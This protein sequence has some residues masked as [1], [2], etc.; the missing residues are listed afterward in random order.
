V[1]AGET[2]I[3]VKDGQRVLELQAYAGDEKLPVK[4]KPSI[5]QSPYHAQASRV[6]IL[7][8]HPNELLIIV[9]NLLGVR[10]YS[11]PN[12]TSKYKGTF[13]NGTVEITRK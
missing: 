3:Q 12:I 4:L 5:P 8:S 2:T 13:A 9:R 7:Q 11:G 10:N 6:K 1:P